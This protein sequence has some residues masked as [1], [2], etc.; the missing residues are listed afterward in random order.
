M[1]GREP[2]RA[3]MLATMARSEPDPRG[4]KPGDASAST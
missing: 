1:G 3:P 4:L 2:I